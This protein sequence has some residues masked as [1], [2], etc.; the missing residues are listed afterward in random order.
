MFKTKS[1]QTTKKKT[2]MSKKK[3]ERFTSRKL[4]CRKQQK[5]T[6]TCS[7]E[8]ILFKIFF[9]DCQKWTRGKMPLLVH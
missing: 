1:K 2:M 6:A 9:S 4:F 5:I 3:K 8:L 7:L